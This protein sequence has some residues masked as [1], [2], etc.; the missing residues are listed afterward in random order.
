MNTWLSDVFIV[1]QGMK[2]L[3]EFAAKEKELDF[4]SI[5][6]M[7]SFKI[8]ASPLLDESMQEVME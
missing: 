6:Q 8:D 2:S 1:L 5:K 3:I 7:A 4:V